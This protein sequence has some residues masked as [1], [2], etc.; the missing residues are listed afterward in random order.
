MSA[1]EKIKELEAEIASLRKNT[2]RFNDVGKAF[3]SGYGSRHYDPEGWESNVVGGYI[4]RTRGSAIYR[5]DEYVTLVVETKLMTIKLEY[6]QTS[7]DSEYTRHVFIDDVLTDT[8]EHVLTDTIEHVVGDFERDLVYTMI[9][10][11]PYSIYWFETAQ[12]REKFRRNS[13]IDVAETE[14]E[15]MCIGELI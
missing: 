14:D 1:R 13:Y 15:E 6:T 7:V 11:M 4:E 9:S 8:I 2:Q 12:I 10:E 5:P 3:I